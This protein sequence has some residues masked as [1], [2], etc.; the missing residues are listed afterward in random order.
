MDPLCCG[1]GLAAAHPF[2]ALDPRPEFPQAP[3][4]GVETD[5]VWMEGQAADGADPLA[6]E[7]VVVLDVVDEVAGPAVDGGELIHGA[8]VDKKV[9]PSAPFSS[10]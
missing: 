3:R 1:Q 9:R 10:G 5:P 4:L 7:A 8:A 6:H 2:T